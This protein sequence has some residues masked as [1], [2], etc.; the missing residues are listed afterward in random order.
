MIERVEFPQ[1]IIGYRM[2]VGKKPFMTVWAYRVGQTLID[3]GNPRAMA[4]FLPLLL[5][6]GP[7]R[8]IYVTHHHEDHSGGAAQ[9]RQLT[10]AR[11]S[12]SQYCAPLLRQGYRLYPYQ[13]WLWGRGPRYQ[14]DTT[15]HIPPLNEL[16]WSTP[17]GDFVIL[18]AP[19]HS[20]DMTVVWLRERNAIFTADLYLAAR[21]RSMRRDEVWSSLKISVGRVLQRTEFDL[22]FCG[23]RPLK[24][25]GKAALAQKY[26][27]MCE[28]ETRM[29]QGLAVGKT[30][31]SL[32]REI[33]GPENWRF[34]LIT[35]GNLRRANMVNSLLGELKPRPDV[36]SRIGRDWAE[37]R[38]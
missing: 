25:G 8:N 15:L 6:D 22:L 29:Q 33:F 16:S 23:H 5:K 7:V 13:F 1:G 34:K 38:F 18:H 9:I 11:I 26:A 28:A 36:L 17:D 35:L 30:R 12:T 24:E 3:S 14:E 19:G 4:E 20:H 37:C 21:L 31:P 32:A 2:G 27:W 10:G